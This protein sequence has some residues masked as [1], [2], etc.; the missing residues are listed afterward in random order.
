MNGRIIFYR[1]AILLLLL[2]LSIT[3]EAQEYGISGEVRLSYNKEDFDTTTRS[4]IEQRYGLNYRGFI[5]HPRL[6]S[7]SIGGTF[8]KEDGRSDGSDTS[9]KGKDYNIGLDFLTGTHFPFSLWATQFTDTYLVLQ[10]ERPSLRVRR[11]LRSIGLDGNV[12]SRKLPNLRY[13]LRQD[14]RKTTGEAEPA[15]ERTRAL[16]LGLSQTWEESAADLSY[17]FRNILYR[18]TL[19]EEN[20]HDVRLSGR[21]RLSR[22][23]TL[24]GNTGFYRN[25]LTDFKEISATTY[26][27][28]IPADRFR[29][30]MNTHYYRIEQPLGKGDFFFNSISGLYRISNAFTATGDTSLYHSTGDFGRETAGTLSGGLSYFAPIARELT[31]SASTN[32]GF[33]AFWGERDQTTMNYNLT[34]T[35]SQ[36]LPK[37]RSNVSTGGSITYSAS[38]LGGRTGAYRLNL[39]IINNYIERLTFQSGLR[40]FQEMTKP[41]RTDAET[42]PTVY[43]EGLTSDTSL[44]YFMPVGPWARIDMSAGLLIDDG[45]TDRRFYYTDATLT[46][47]IMRNLSMRSTLRYMH[48]GIRPS[49]TI[50]G[51]IN[52]DYNLRRVFVNLRYE[53]WREK[54]LD[55][56]STRATTFL[57]ITRTF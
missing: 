33:S 34:S 38:S 46:Y 44:T 25:T 12:Y 15:G 32:L 8:V 40:Y 6:L 47:L 13:S 5:Y 28:Y 45:A 53:L 22:A 35:L 16:L 51:S 50:S 20:I 24:S 17:H 30:S 54:R 26:L 36:N 14:D 57:Q 11:T 1:L 39:N 49:D 2:P 3:A 31:L 37:I 7:Y 55:T 10:P 23:L 29:G 41:D 56:T 4:S 19:E 52:L 48:E 43:R 21:T 27:D 9:A 42:P 18:I